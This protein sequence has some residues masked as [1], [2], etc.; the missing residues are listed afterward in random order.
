VTAGATDA[1]P[2]AVV[3]G[4]GRNLGRAMALTL[5]GAGVRVVLTGTSS[6]GI[7]ETL[8]SGAADADALLLIAD[9]ADPGSRDTIVARALEAFGRVDILVNNAA[10]VPGHI[11]PDWD[12]TGEPQAWT[13]DDGLY[14]RFFEINAVAPQ[15]LARACIPGMIERSW[16]RIVNVT[17][18]LDS[19]LQL[20]P[21]RAS[22]AARRRQ[23]VSLLTR[24]EYLARA[25]SRV[26]F[27]HYA[28]STSTI[29][30]CSGG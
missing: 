29:G 24:H 18:S 17:T 15:A 9:L 2:V 12:V 14:R 11:W 13:L 23:A 25:D 8:R 1:R 22:K 26:R 27:G 6:A 19:M 30:V 7:E 4:A 21:Y 5:L 28:C 10:I 20:W 16:G 3:T